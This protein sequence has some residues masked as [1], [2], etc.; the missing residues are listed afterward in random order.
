MTRKLLT[1]SFWFYLLLLL[2]FPLALYGGLTAS[3]LANIRL[4][5]PQLYTGLQVLT[6]LVSLLL[7]ILMLMRLSFDAPHHLRPESVWQCWLACALLSYALLHSV[8]LIFLQNTQNILLY[9]SSSALA[10]VIIL[11]LLWSPNRWWRGIYPTVPAL[12][13]ILLSLIGVSLCLHF[14]AQNN[15]DWLILCARLSGFGFLLHSLY[16][17]DTAWRLK[18]YTRL[19]LGI[20][21]L[22][23]ALYLLLL[24][25]M[26]QWS[27][28]WWSVYSLNLLAHL[29]LLVYLFSWAHRQLA[30]RRFFQQRFTTIHEL[31]SVGLFYADPQGECHA[32]NPRFEQMTGLS[33]QQLQGEGWKHS[34]HPE[35]RPLI[36][37]KWQEAIKYQRPC[38]AEFRLLQKNGESI[39]VLC[40]GLP[41]TDKNEKMLSFLSTCTDITALKQA[42]EELQLYREQ[43]EQ[44]VA[45]RTRALRESESRFAGILETAYDAII[46]T[47]EDQRVVLFNRSA[48]QI[49]G[50]HRDEVLGHPLG[51]LLPRSLTAR[52]H[53]H[54]LNFSATENNQYQPMC[55]HSYVQGLR[56]D[57]TEFPAEG[58]ISKMTQGDKSLYTA[59]LRDL[60]ASKQA[61]AHMRA[62]QQRYITLFENSPVVLLEEDLSAI[63]VYLDNLVDKGVE[64]LRQYM[65]NNASVVSYCAALIKIVDANQNCLKL[66][67]IP[68]KHTL[69]EQLDGIFTEE[70]LITYKD[71][72]LNF[73]GGRTAFT[74]ETSL[75][76]AQGKK[77]FVMLRATLVPDYEVHWGRVIVSITDIT[78]RKQGEIEL[79]LAK[80]AAESANHAK[81]AFLASMS[82]ELRTP[83]NSI[84]G[85]AQLLERD[86]G[87]DHM[88]RDQA[89]TIRQAGEHLLTLLNDILDMAKLQTDKQGLRKSLFSFPEF[90]RKL[91]E[92]MR[93]QASQAGLEFRFMPQC[94]LPGVVLGDENRLRQVLF[95]LLSNAIKFTEKGQVSL[96]ISRKQDYLCFQVEDTGI[97]INTE[98][99]NTL[100]QPFQQ[101][102]EMSYITPGS[103]LGL[104]LSQGFI[105][106]MGGELHVKSV[107]E[108][109]S[110]FWFDIPLPEE[111]PENLQT[112]LLANH[113]ALD[114]MMEN[115]VPPSLLTEDEAAQLPLPSQDNLR[116]LHELSLIGD[117]EAIIHQLTDIMAV[118]SETEAFCQHL[119]QMADSF[120]IQQIRNLLKRCLSQ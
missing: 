55:P 24:P 98:Y 80:E 79:N 36:Q 59:I 120:Q 77:R 8:Y 104:A 72:L 47:D 96:K 11:I 101:G 106:M 10:A 46:A 92:I 18:R 58:S 44:K 25:Q 97:G 30:Q 94:T 41:E 48:E 40:Q 34:V 117:V 52:H 90:L 69:H 38:R 78:E 89:T 112:P 85:F 103:G 87:L 70:T 29:V 53:L 107:L 86:A 88:Q 9:H 43:L 37:Q 14:D 57:G 71:I 108:Q 74:G 116:T 27:A 84:M 4:Y 114:Q 119:Q 23:M 35:D 49:F 95:N 102:G 21:S 1:P 66:F 111:P 15:A 45:E 91:L 32:V 100:F 33:E 62:T 28:S 51:M 31:A 113:D 81:T 39:W 6:I 56:K 60:S 5:N 105:K 2:L 17:W 99:L 3:G 115:T 26:P 82:H 54:F 118:H 75:L 16:F 68:D 50:Y 19:W 63:K 109:G 61:E 13:S 67:E 22:L 20:W 7:S 42:E 76:T 65:E 110:L 12:L 64:N 73:Y 83:L 93:L